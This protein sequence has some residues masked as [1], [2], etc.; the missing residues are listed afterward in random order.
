MFRTYKI[1]L[2]LIALLLLV[3]AG[4][5]GRV[6]VATVTPSPTA[7]PD[8]AATEAVFGLLGAQTAVAETQ[9]ALEA[10]RAA[11]AATADALATAQAELDAT[12]TAR[13]EALAARE[14]A[15]VTAQA[16]IAAA[17]TA[18][19]N[20]TS[21]L[22]QSLDAVADEQAALAE[23]RQ[24]F[25]ATQAAVATTSQAFQAELSQTATAQAAQAETIAATQT[26][27][28][29]AQ[30][31]LAVT[32]TA[33]APTP[34]PPPAQ[35][36]EIWEEIAVDELG[37]VFTAPAGFARLD[38]SAP[39]IR[40][41]YRDE[42]GVTGLITLERGALTKLLGAIPT[43][44]DLADPVGVL[45]ELLTTP[46][47]L[48]Q[49]S[50]TEAPTTY[51]GSQFSAAQ[52]SG[53]SL[54]LEQAMRLTLLQ[55]GAEDWLLIGISAPESILER[56]AAPMLQSI[57]PT[58]EG[59]A[60]QPP[61]A[62]LST[63]GPT[64]SPDET[65]TRLGVAFAIPDGWDFS[66]DSDPGL[67]RPV[68]ELSATDDSDNFIGLARFTSD[69]FTQV[70]VA[71]PAGLSPTEALAILADA[72]RADLG[73][74]YSGGRVNDLALG[75]FMGAW[76]QFRSESEVQRVYLFQM[77]EDDWL[78]V[79]AVGPREP[80]NEFSRT[81]LRDF[82][83]SLVPLGDE[84][85]ALGLN[86]EIP[87]GWTMEFTPPEEAMPANIRLAPPEDVDS[88]RE[89][90]LARGSAAQFSVLNLP[91][92]ADDAVTALQPVAETI[93]DSGDL[94]RRVRVDPIQINAFSGATASLR[95][96]N[97]AARLFLFKLDQDDWL[98]IIAF[99]AWDDFNAFTREDLRMVL[100]SLSLPTGQK[101]A[102]IEPIGP[103]EEVEVVRVSD[104]DTIY[105]LLNGVE[106]SVR[107]IGIDTPEAHHPSG[108]A[109]WLGY[110]A[111]QMTTQ[112]LPPGT[113][114]YL[115]SDIRDRDDFG[116]LLRYV[117]LKDENG[118]WLMLEAALVRAGLAHVRTYDEDRYVPYFLALERE[119]QRERLGVWGDPPPPPPVESLARRDDTVWAVNPNGDNVPLLYDAAALGNVPD[120]VAIW[121]N[122]IR[123]TVRDVYYVYPDDIDPQ[124]GQPVSPEKVGY[125]Y[126][127]EINDFRG[128]VPEA[129]LRLEAPE[130][131]VEPP[132][133]DIIAYAQPFVVGDEPVAVHAAPGSDEVLGAF[134]PES[135]VQV[136]RLG[137]DPATGEWW[138]WADTGT[139][140][141][142]LPLANLNRLEASR[143]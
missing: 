63:P 141:G 74:G 10:E 76:T 84:G 27:L 112:M 98:L 132:Q 105:V 47:I 122:G 51:P 86:F 60:A 1:L 19:A 32:Q 113:T 117:W 72:V 90:I 44:L 69:E 33:M 40:L 73:E 94:G 61:A 68:V 39:A 120:P 83:Q 114:V 116:R 75:D 42:N 2:P 18:I 96:E 136:E 123:A 35:S 46:P 49:F 125:W 119:A 7:T 59:P 89:I 8:L 99:A 23:D 56:W 55:L 29:G 5:E 43:S 138:L 45:S 3:G 133:T 20:D 106:E 118:D 13:A 48:E 14:A 128:W 66:A 102:T 50:A 100:D 143:R 65:A 101:T 92:D 58:N 67:S 70:G 115:E 85:V 135:R 87:E 108:G 129:W 71:L 139:V 24:A 130:N 80:F 88:T 142:W 53:T 127:L 82:L 4:C 81:V 126:W 30:Q 77:G 104:G 62:A 110:T 31:A 121:P 137:I 52:V 25:E 17:R 6:T 41:A 91:P 28:A 34:P 97:N 16:T 36:M 12:G 15:L 54:E 22:Q 93:R 21:V 134:E 124:T 64:P 79:F 9:A 131:A 78:L 107:I 11:L 111:T 140:D 37:L 26:A 95:G 38:S 103:L 109:D 57:T